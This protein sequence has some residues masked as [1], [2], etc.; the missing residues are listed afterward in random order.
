MYSD[1]V[2]L[3]SNNLSAYVI[4]APDFA[5]LCL[6]I[7]YVHRVSK[8]TCGNGARNLIINLL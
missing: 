1:T 2:T 5:L 6:E 4:S 8:A 7:C 3:F